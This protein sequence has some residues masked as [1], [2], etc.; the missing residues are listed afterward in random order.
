[1]NVNPVSFGRTIRVNAQ[2]NVAKRMAELVNQNRNVE[3]REERSSQQK[4]KT[5]FY[6]ANTGSAQAIELNKKSYIVTGDESQAVSDLL[7]DRGIH[8]G[9]A[10]NAYG[11]GEMFELAKDEEDKRCQEY[12]GYIVENS[13]E[14]VS[15]SVKYTDVPKSKEFDS[16]GTRVKIKS[17]NVVL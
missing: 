5:L 12:L 2:L 4:L 13:V 16:V 17:I 6:D 3:D 10:K 15:I 8:I 14:P 7:L 11:E 9:L 1:M